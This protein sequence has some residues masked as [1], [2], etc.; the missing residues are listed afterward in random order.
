MKRAM[1]E[2]AA[3]SAKKDKRKQSPGS[4]S[5]ESDD[6]A[7]APEKRKR[8]KQLD[9]AL[10]EKQDDEKTIKCAIEKQIGKNARALEQLVE[11]RN[12]HELSG[13]FHFDSILV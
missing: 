9:W 8:Q 11:A 3:A 10:K 6:L 13:I 2:R 1:L 4:E 7:A 5:K 12:N